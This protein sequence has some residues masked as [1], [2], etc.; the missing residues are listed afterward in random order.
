MPRLLAGTSGFDYD[1]WKGIFYP[2]DLPRKQRLSFYG[3]AFPAVEINASFYRKPAPA[4]VSG[5]AAQ[6]PEGFRFAMKVWQRITHQKRLRDCAELVEAFA[7]AARALGS[8]AGPLLYQLPPNLKKDLPL[9]RDFLAGLPRDLR[10]AFEFRNPSWFDDDVYAA[11]RDAGC[12]LCVAE[13]EESATPLVRTAPFGYFR[14]R[15]EDYDPA[16]LSRWAAA[17]QSAGF[18]DDLFVFFKHEDAA[19]G[20]G[21]ARELTRLASLAGA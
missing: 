6:V 18:T 3:S 9:L 17:L 2:A 19:I 15:R 11:L 1:P 16:M 21:Y 7:D 14:L 10:A 4:T 13:T 8:R 5:W 12:A 20:V